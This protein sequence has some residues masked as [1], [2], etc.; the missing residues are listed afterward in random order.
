MASASEFENHCWK[1]VYDEETLRASAKYARET[2]IDDSPALLLVDLYNFVYD[3]GNR[4]LREIQDDYPGTCGEFAWAAIEPTKKLIAA[5]R[6]ADIPIIY[7]TRRVVTAIASTTRGFPKARGTM[8]PDAYDIWKDFTPQPGDTLIYKERA[9]GFYG[10]PLVAYLNKMR[11]HSLIICGES[12]SGCL[13]NT[14]QD[15]YMNSYHVSVAEEC[16]YDRNQLSH[17]ASLFDMH[18]KYADVMHTDDIVHQ[19]NKRAK[20]EPLAVAGSRAR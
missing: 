19:L 17:K 4:P 14:V 16:C 9:S 20:A 3:G 5:A 15:A 18:H 12:T 7:L 10:T 8:K 6:A 2:K 13:R 1:D 11:I